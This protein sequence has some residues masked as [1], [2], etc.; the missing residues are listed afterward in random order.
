MGGVD[1]FGN[2]VAEFCGKVDLFG[3][4]LGLQV[5]VEGRDDVAVNL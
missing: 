4:I 1:K 3:R 5:S 2:F